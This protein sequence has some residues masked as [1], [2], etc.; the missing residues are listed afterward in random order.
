MNCADCNLQLLFPEPPPSD[1]ITVCP[2]HFQRRINEMGLAVQAPAP[3]S[4]FGV[5]SREMLRD[6][7]SGRTLW[8][9]RI[10]RA[11]HPLADLRELPPGIYDSVH[12]QGE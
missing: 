5:L 9:G 3:V 7:V 4:D 2:K 10:D 8:F 1:A 12:V 6:P 11:M